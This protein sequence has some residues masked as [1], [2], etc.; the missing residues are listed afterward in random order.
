M[1]TLQYDMSLLLLSRVHSLMMDK[2]YS[3]VSECLIEYFSISSWNERCFY[4]LACSLANYVTASTHVYVIMCI[5][6]FKHY[7]QLYRVFAL[8]SDFSI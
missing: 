7:S 4:V 2:L 3:T 5:I 8:S 6:W 1:Q